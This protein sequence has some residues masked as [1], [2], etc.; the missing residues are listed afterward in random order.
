MIFR[1]P[2]AFLIKHFRLI[3]LLL[4]IL[5]GYVIY[6][7]YDIMVFFNN[8]ILND[9]SGTF[10][11]GFFAEYISLSLFLAILLILIGLVG[12]LA[13]FINKK[14]PIKM[15]IT[16]IVYFV[17]YIVFLNII[18][19]VMIGLETDVLSAQSAR[20][21]RDLSFIA[22][23]PFIVFLIM[24]LIRGLGFNIHKF[25]FEKDIKELE[26]SSQDN[27]EVEV[28]IR[29]DGFKLKRNIRRF[30]REFTYYVKEN[31]FIFTII[32]IVSGLGLGFIIYKALPVITNERY[33]QN[34]TFYINGLT[35]NIEDSI[36]TNLDY[37][38]N[39][40]I[41]DGYYLV[42]KLRI[43][44]P[45][46]DIVN[47]DYNNFRLE[48]NNRYVYPTVDKSIYFIDYATSETKRIIKAN[49]NQ[50]YAIAFQIKEK[51][52]KKNYD[53][54]INSGYAFSKR[55]KIGK[56]N[57]VN[58]TPIIINKV[59][60]ANSVDLNEEL[61]FNNSYLDNTKLTIKNVEIT[62][63]YIYDYESCIK[64]NC[65]IYKDIISV[66]YNNSNNTLLVLDFD[67]EIDKN[68][69][70]AQY[71]KSINGF[72]DSFA[73]I[74]YGNLGNEK[75]LSVKNVTPNKLKNKIILET[76]NKI[77]GGAPLYLTLTVRNKE[78]KIRLK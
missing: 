6:R 3:H 39:K 34:D 12:I 63:K 59:N 66:N 52:V 64:D 4:T 33:R 71:S 77:T 15:Y 78:F 35:Y 8:Y 17:G 61:K 69:P 11:D 45:L 20:V 40:I 5:T 18:K 55:I 49:S 7:A 27:E 53:I 58:I 72:I 13:L 14:K 22:I 46:N 54:K 29:K 23:I 41:E 37:Q 30:I 1:K 31:K 67:Y 24:F 19:S 16:G 56:F 57:Y 32:C 9:Y 38:G 25:N 48:V 21:Y 10:Y 68:A 47:L 65:S 60:T 42:L 36:I 74:T 26:I 62:P 70:F 50:V 44:N 76:S 28:T 73:S 75:T 43:E 2:Y 51:D